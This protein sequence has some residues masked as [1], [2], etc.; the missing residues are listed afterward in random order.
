[1]TSIIHY[2]KFRRLQSL[3]NW[4]RKFYWFIEL[5]KVAEKLLLYLIGDIATLVTVEQ[6]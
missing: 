1:M 5:G 4:N 3:F 2:P 6:I